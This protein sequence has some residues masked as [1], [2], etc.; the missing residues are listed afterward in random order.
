MASAYQ[1]LHEPRSDL[2][3]AELWLCQEFYVVIHQKMDEGGSYLRHHNVLAC[4]QEGLD[5]EV[6]LY[7]LDT[8][9]S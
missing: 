5:L 7:P 2:H 3:M 4:P 9:G 1:V 8:A 6:L